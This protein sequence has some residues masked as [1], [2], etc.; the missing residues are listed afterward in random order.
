MKVIVKGLLVVV[1]GGVISGVAAVHVYEAR[2]ILVNLLVN[3]L[4][5]ALVG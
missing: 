5:T 2:N 1:I 3:L 4:S